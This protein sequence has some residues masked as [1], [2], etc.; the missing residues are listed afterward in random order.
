MQ[1]R[2][3][4]FDPWSKKIP[5]ASGQLEKACRQQWRPCA[6]NNRIIITKIEL[7]LSFWESLSM[8]IPVWTGRSH[9]GK[10]PGYFYSCCSSFSTHMQNLWRKESVK[11]QQISEYV[12]LL[13]KNMNTWKETI[14]RKLLKILLNWSIVLAYDLSL[15]FR[16]QHSDS[17]FLYI[18]IHLK[19]LKI[20][21][22]FHVLYSIS[23]LLIYSMRSSYVS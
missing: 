7:Y 13:N 18:I 6:A 17:I 14:I 8:N 15:G 21:A 22:C 11:N 10:D 5:H 3:H 23:L 1:C 12:T 2:G 16:C 19:L 4:W 20:M 9:G